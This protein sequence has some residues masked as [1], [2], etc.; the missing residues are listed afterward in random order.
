MVLFAVRH[1]ERQ[2]DPIDGLSSAGSVRA[3]RL[4]HMLSESGVSVGDCS[5]ACEPETLAPL[6]SLLGDALLVHEVSAGGPGGPEAHIEAVPTA[7][8]SLREGTVVVV[9]SQSNTVGPI[10]QNIGGTTPRPIG[11]A[12]RDR[13][14]ILFG[15]GSSPKTLLQLRYNAIRP[16]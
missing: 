8:R 3:W 5:D 14:L 4:A 7:V 12:E 2:P 9:V 15:A 13:M 16:S 1:A 6:K 10:I 11:D